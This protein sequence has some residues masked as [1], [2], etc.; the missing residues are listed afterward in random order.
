MAGPVVLTGATGFIGTAILESLITSGRPVRALTRRQRPDTD[1]VQWIHG[2]L[3]DR[4]ALQELV[5][6]A[7]AII[8]CAGAVRG[9]S[10]NDF[11]RVNTEGTLNLVETAV[12]NA[13][14]CRFLL[15]SSLAAREP[16]ISWYAASK[17]AAEQTLSEHAGRMPWT[18]LRPTAVYGPGDRELSPLLRITRYGI[19]PMPGRTAT[20][21]SLLHVNDL[22][23]A[24]L[25]WLSV[26]EPVPGIYELDDGT[27]GGY[28]RHSLAEIASR[29]WGRPVRP[30]A[31]PASLMFM[32]AGTNLWLSRLF[33]YS[34]ML[35]PGK[36]RELLHHDW[37]CDNTPLARA[38]DWQP[39]VRL[40]DALQDAT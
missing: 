6:G 19:L 8:H 22:V 40:P 9:A 4:E 25:S 15:V 5:A 37:A 38:L 34:P 12:R 11:S 10:L 21:F 16:Q 1:T 29:V 39:R 36:V 7:D 27:P 31:V 33:R 18:V 26:G 28:D 2:D 13:S 35:T 14:R 23:A 3:H 24:I 30:L 20:R 32:A 17:Y